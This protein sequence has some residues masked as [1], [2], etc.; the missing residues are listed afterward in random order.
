MPNFAAVA[1][2]LQDLPMQPFV[3]ADTQLSARDLLALTLDFP[4]E[5]FPV[6]RVFPVTGCS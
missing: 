5:H 1:A 3:L 6:G 2:D 4:S